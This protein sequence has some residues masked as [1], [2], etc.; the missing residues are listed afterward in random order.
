MESPD[1]NAPG[2]E[3]ES[4]LLSLI[5]FEAERCGY[6]ENSEEVMG[7]FKFQIVTLGH[8]QGQRMDSVYNGLYQ[9]A[10]QNYAEVYELDQGEMA[11]RTG[12]S[13]PL[14]QDFDGGR[15]DWALNS[16]NFDIL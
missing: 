3:V 4:A 12:A 14:K 5:N 13:V 7:A 1:Y 8:I 9:Q 15:L 16:V 6:P 10:L 11:L 2:A